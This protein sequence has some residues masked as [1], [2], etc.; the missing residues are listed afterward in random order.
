MTPLDVDRVAPE[1]CD[2]IR[3][4]PVLHE[5]VDLAAVARLVL[6]AVDPAA[7]AVELPTTLVDAVRTAV[8]RMPKITLVV[9]EEPGEEALVWTATP[10]DPLVEALRWAE[11][12]DRPWFLID[13]DV[14]D[15]E[16]RPQPLPDPWCTWTLGVE[17]YI[18]TVVRLASAASATDAEERRERGMAHN[19]RDASRTAGGSVL[20]LVGATHAA[21]LAAAL[22]S[23]TATPF[24]RVRR[25]RVSTRHLH[26]EALTAMLPD[27]PLAHAVWEMVRSGSV[28]PDAA[29]ADA[30]SRRIELEV[31]GL[32]VISG[33]RSDD[34][35]QR[36]DG[37]VRYAASTAHR[38]APGGRP[39]PDRARLAG[40]VWRIAAASWQ[41]QTREV[42]HPWQRRTFFDVVRRHARVQGLLVPGIY[43]LVAGARGVADDNLAWEAFDA[44]RTYPWQEPQAELE[45]ARLEGDLLDLGVRTVRFRR[46]FMRVKQRPVAVPVRRHP[47]PDDPFEWLEAFDGSAICSYPPEDVVVEDYGRFLRHKAVSVLASERARSE[48]F[49]TSMLD[50]VDLRE[51]LRRWHEGR[52]WVR[53]LG[54]APGDAGSVVVVF[55][56][57]RDGRGYPY[58]MTWLGEHDQESDMAFYATDPTRQV[59]GPGIM[60]ATYGGFLLTSPPGRLFDVWHDPDYRDAQSKPEVLLQAAVDYSREKNVVYVAPQPPPSRVADWASRRG[61]RVV[62]LPLGS[63]S[64]VTVRRIRV[65]HILSGHDKR[66][67]AKDY[68][69]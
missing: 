33:G 21:R 19:L 35:R 55:D 68:I 8:R 17:R 3:I 31:L 11:E 4:L 64:P 15:P 41:E 58:L 9:S 60:R 40:V 32:R 45:T 49:T 14:R 16:R 18:E 66:S 37:V 25:E 61:R 57:D 5:R 62:Y 53:E 44:A 2:G 29:F 22:R 59:V 1:A 52:V 7:V 30:V 6:E 42:A 47:A 43:E 24:A 67:V 12:H 65:L 10:G 46:R 69:W 26:P 51:T 63:L 48:P 34:R 27:P 28:P 13:P 54:R 39:V 23:P 50:G 56:D 36:A 38:P 20:A